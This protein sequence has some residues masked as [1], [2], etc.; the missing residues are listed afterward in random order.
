MIE[1]VNIAFADGTSIKLKEVPLVLKCKSNLI[2]LGQMQD[3]KIIYYNKNSFILLVQDAI[4]IAQAQKDRNLFVLIFTAP[5]KVIWANAA[6][7]KHIIMTT[8]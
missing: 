4:P 5:R 3:N 1:I 6:N 7:N 8:R 2:L